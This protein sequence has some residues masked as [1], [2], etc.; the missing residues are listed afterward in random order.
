M[1]EETKKIFDGSSYT[2]D[3]QIS[4]RLFERDLYRFSQLPQLWEFLL[5]AT[6]QKCWACSCANKEFLLE[7]G[8][9]RKDENCYANN[10]VELLRKVK[11][12]K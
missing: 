2:G 11:E 1:T 9:P 10:W 3:R 12:G 8:C 4:I 6:C 5:D 7:H